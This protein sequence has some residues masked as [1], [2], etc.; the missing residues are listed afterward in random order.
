[1]KS[2]LRCSLAIFVLLAWR[3]GVYAQSDG[4][5]GDNMPDLSVWNGI[6]LGAG[7]G[8]GSVVHDIDLGVDG[9]FNGS[10]DFIP[11]SMTV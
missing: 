10:V 2:F 3:T 4:Y 5:K 1:M 7:I 6:W 9:S 8:A 11:L